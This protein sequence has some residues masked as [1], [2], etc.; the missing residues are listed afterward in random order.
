M[1]FVRVFKDEGRSYAPVRDVDVSCDSLTC[2]ERLVVPGDTPFLIDW[3]LSDFFSIGHFF[4]IFRV[5]ICKKVLKMLEF[6]IFLAI[7]GILL[8]FWRKEVIKS[9]TLVSRD[10]RALYGIRRALRLLWADENLAMFDPSKDRRA[11]IPG[12]SRRKKVR[13]KQTGREA[14]LNA[15]KKR[16]KRGD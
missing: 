6:V 10:T 3:R 13:F 15:L 1:C 7:F 4:T 11:F 8:Y 5:F 9:L 16:L 14:A 2:L 12:E